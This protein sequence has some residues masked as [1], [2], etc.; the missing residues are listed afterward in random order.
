[1]KFARSRRSR[2]GGALHYTTPESSYRKHSNAL[3]WS[4]TGMTSMKQGAIDAHRCRR[5]F[6]PRPAAF[7]YAC[8]KRLCADGLLRACGQ[9]YR[10]ASH[11]GAC[12]RASIALASG[13][14]LISDVSCRE[15]FMLDGAVV[16]ELHFCSQSPIAGYA[17]GR[18]TWTP[19]MRSCWKTDT[20]SGRK[21]TV[22]ND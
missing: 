22:R 16:I 18:W 21:T 6:Q 19:H 9:Q 12:D 8:G 15:S 1:M 7:R 13:Y 5:R 11:D 3:L 14:S 17:R 20:G 2:R 10:D 4:S